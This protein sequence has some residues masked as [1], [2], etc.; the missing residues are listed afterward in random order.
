MCTDAVL[1]IRHYSKSYDEGRLA[2]GDVSLRVMPGDI[3]GFIGHNGAGKTTVIRSVV[4]VLDF[5]EGEILVDGVARRFSGPAE[6][7]AAGITAVFPINRL[8]ED[9]IPFWDLEFTAED[10]E[11]TDSSAAAIAICGMLELLQY[12]PDGEDKTLFKNAIELSMQ[13]LY[14]N[15][16]T[17]DTPEANGLLLHAV[18]SKPNNVGIDEMNIWGCYFYMEALKRMKNGWNLYW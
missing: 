9:F 3:Y 18:Y 5:Q 16:T 1:D 4:G 10:K 15:Y 12:L 11:E 7:K 14:D 13:S 2:A 17:K 8:P 6:A